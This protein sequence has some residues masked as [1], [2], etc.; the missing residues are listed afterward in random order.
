MTDQP[1]PPS[2]YP[3]GPWV[4]IAAICERPLVDT[5][6]ILS[7][8]RIVDRIKLTTNDPDVLAAPAPITVSALAMIVLTSGAAE[9]SGVF[10][11]RVVSPSGLSSPGEPLPLRFPK[12]GATQRVTVNIELRVNEAGIYWI[13]VLFSDRVLT[14]IPLEVVLALEVAEPSDQSDPAVVSS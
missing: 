2:E 10:A 7:I 9:I 11:L 13:D 3:P 4:T 8:I 14:R 5:D 1:T 6:G 12:A